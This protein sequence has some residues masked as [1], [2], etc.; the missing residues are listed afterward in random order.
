MARPRFDLQ[1]HS[2]HSDGALPAAAVVERAADGGVEL[3]ALSDHDTVSGVSEAL[4][5][6]ERAGVRVVPAVEI[7][8][9][10]DGAPAGRELHVLGYDIDHT[11]ALLTERLSEFLADR[12]RRTMRMA[13]ALREVGLE[14]DERELAA[15][16]AEGQPIGRPHLAEAALRCPANA[17]RLQQEGIDEIGSFIRAYLVEGRPAFRLRETP[18]VTQAVEAIHEAGGVAIWAHPFWDLSEPGEVLEGIE[19]FRALGI[20]GVEAFYITHT[21]EQTELLA[22]RTASLGLLS[23]GSSDFHGPENRLFSRFL[24][25]ETY[26]LEPNLGRIASGR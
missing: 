22:E 13:G 11:A 8:A 18:T 10:D 25:F 1:S 19:R 17:S 9:V 2:T 26:G 6:G 14:L 21:R 20:D 15:R 16:V 5:A 7:S 23:T 12:E 4:A 3:L 24:A